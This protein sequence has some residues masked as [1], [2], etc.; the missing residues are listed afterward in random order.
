MDGNERRLDV[1]LGIGAC[2]NCDR[3]NLMRCARFCVR[4]APADDVP[5]PL[6]CSW[7][8]CWSRAASAFADVGVVELCGVLADEFVP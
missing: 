6:L 8:S 7:S 1:M 3:R 4:P 2:A 5:L